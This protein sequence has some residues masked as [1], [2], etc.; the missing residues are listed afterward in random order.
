[1]EKRLRH[2]TLAAMA[3]QLSLDYRCLFKAISQ[4][5]GVGLVPCPNNATF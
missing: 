4:N 1:M 2:Y 5:H 3:L